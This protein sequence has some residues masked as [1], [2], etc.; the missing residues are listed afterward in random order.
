MIDL[1]GRG[2]M[3]RLLMWSAVVAALWTVVTAAPAGAV[4]GSFAEP[5]Y[6]KT[7]SNNYFW[8]SWTAVD[9]FTGGGATDYRYY[10]CMRTYKDGVLVEDYIANNPPGSANCFAARTSSTGAR[11]GTAYTYPFTSSTVLGEGSTY[12]QCL[13]GYSFYFTSWLVDPGWACSSTTVDRSKPQIATSI[14]GTADYTNDARLKLHIDYWDAI[15][16]PWYGSNQRAS[17]WTCL[18]AG[19]PCTPSLA[20]AP[21]PNCSVA[22]AGWGSL[23]KINQFDCAADVSAQADA[24]YY[25]CARAADWALPDNP[26]DSN[27]FKATSDQANV[28]DVSCGWVTLDRKPPSVSV[29]LSATTAAVG[30]LVT[31]SASASD[32]VS[33]TGG[34]YAWTFGDN[35]A[36]ATGATG[37]SATHTYTQPGTYQIAATTTD[38][39]GNTGAGTATITV[40]PATPG[41]PGPT[42]T[43]AATPAPTPGSGSGNSPSSGVTPGTISRSAVSTQAGG[44]STQ[45]SNLPKLRVIAPKTF[46]S[47]RRYMLLG[48]TA[49][50]KGA[51]RVVL[52]K[53]SKTIASKTAT[54]GRSGGWGLKLNVPKRLAAGRYTLTLKWTPAGATRTSTTTL[55][56]KV[57]PKRT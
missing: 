10:L 23:A 12:K 8:W 53:G 29:S 3:R 38:G 56:V 31:A 15:S 2:R 9:G 49:Q 4:V 24:K 44:G 7:A 14:D 30:Q 11:S 41:S 21:D 33:G 32:A 47:G 20:A 42:P 51:L 17:N 35:T 37:A 48:V 1:S 22:Q 13:T 52:R 36:G 39:A 40:Q 28:S 46:R 34:T 25:F 43:P 6:T 54:I 57:L 18:S 55:K 5:T 45:T 27:Q 50:A 26:L 16:P 19:A